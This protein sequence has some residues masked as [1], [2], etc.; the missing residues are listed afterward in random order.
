MRFYWL[1]FR[2]DKC[3][4]AHIVKKG[5]HETASVFTN[6]VDVGTSIGDGKCFFKFRTHYHFIN[7]SDLYVNII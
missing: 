2:L 5:M 1:F 6:E 4:Y 3:L 7:N